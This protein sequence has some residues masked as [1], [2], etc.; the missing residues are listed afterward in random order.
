MWKGIVWPTNCSKQLLVCQPSK[1]SLLNVI[2]SFG[3]CYDLKWHGMLDY[4]GTFRTGA[5]ACN[6]VCANVSQMWSLCSWCR[7]YGATAMYTNFHF[8]SQCSKWQKIYEMF[9]SLQNKTSHNNIKQQI[10]LRFT[11]KHS[12]FEYAISMQMYVHLDSS[13][14]PSASSVHYEFNRNVH[15]LY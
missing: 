6:C 13:L 15:V 12:T 4:T 1:T 9:R 7:T 2:A 11:S 10:T 5:Y 8:P 14:L 3:V